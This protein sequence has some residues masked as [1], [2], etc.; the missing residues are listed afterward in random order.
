MQVGGKTGGRPCHKKG[1]ASAS[2]YLERVRNAG[3][4]YPG[5]VASRFAR[6]IHPDLNVELAGTMRSPVSFRLV[7]TVVVPIEPAGAACG[8]GR[9]VAHGFGDAHPGSVGQAMGRSHQVTAVFCL[10]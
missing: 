2:S 3:V 6:L 5:H 7:V 4:N 8:S 1:G 9:C 10:W